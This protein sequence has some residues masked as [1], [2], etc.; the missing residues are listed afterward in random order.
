[1]GEAGQR[2]A[3]THNSWKSIA[4]QM[5]DLYETVRSAAAARYGGWRRAI[6]SA[7]APTSPRSLGS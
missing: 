7:P 3:M 5:E 2:H 6:L 1:M 4:A